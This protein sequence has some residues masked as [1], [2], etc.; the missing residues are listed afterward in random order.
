MR[1]IVA[2]VVMLI[3]GQPLAADEIK[4]GDD[5]VQYIVRTVRHQ[6][7]KKHESF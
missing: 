1:L 2:L 6:I 7:A 5:L 3:C 4:T